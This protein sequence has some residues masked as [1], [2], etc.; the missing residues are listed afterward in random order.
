MKTSQPR[1]F[2]VLLWS[3]TMIFLP[4][5]HASSQKNEDT[6]KRLTKLIN[7]SG[8][9]Y[10][11]DIRITSQ[12]NDGGHSVAHLT[13]TRDADPRGDWLQFHLEGDT[14]KTLEFCLHCLPEGGVTNC[15]PDSPPPMQMLGSTLPGSSLPWEEIL[16]G[17]CGT[18]V[19]EAVPTASES[20]HQDTFGYTVTISN[21][22]FN[23]G[24]ITTKITMDSKSK[25]PL[26][27]DRIDSEGRLVR[28]IRVL[29]I[30]RVGGWRGIRQAIIESDDG[31]VL[32]EITGFKK[33]TGQFK[34][35]RE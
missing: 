3:F 25:D 16:V 5:L 21:A 1:L 27:F 7:R 6:I 34:P 35:S 8:R 20:G 2:F 30:G 9:D 13:A 19:V 17:S 14:T 28:R 23:P 18:W 12:G 24:W 31:R 32:M 10:R 33:G 26:F 15:N 4:Q 11:V 29:E 22:A